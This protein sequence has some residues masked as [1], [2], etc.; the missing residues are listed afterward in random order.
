MV[1]LFLYLA[2]LLLLSP[3]VTTQDVKIASA[4]NACPSGYT[5]LT[6]SAG[7]QTAMGLVN[8]KPFSGSEDESNWPAGCYFCNKVRGCTNGVWFNAHPTGNVVRKVKS[9]CAVPGWEAGLD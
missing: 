1:H 9:I 8:K 6:T 2:V 7:C 3:S 4:G 5:K